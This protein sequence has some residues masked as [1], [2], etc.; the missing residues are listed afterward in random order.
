MHLVVNSTWEKQFAFG[1]DFLYGLSCI[2]CAA[3]LLYPAT[4]DQDIRLCDLSFI[5]YPGI[6]YQIILHT[7]SAL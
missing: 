2:M 5:N 1:I 3:D 6:P 4:G 7:F